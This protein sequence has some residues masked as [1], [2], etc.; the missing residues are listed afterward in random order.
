MIGWTDLFQLLLI[1]F[2][3]FIFLLSLLSILHCSWIL[4]YCFV[5]LGQSCFDILLSSTLVSLRVYNMGLDTWIG[6]CHRNKSWCR[7]QENVVGSL[8]ELKVHMKMM[9]Y[10]ANVLVC[11][12]GIGSCIRQNHPNNKILWLKLYYGLPLQLRLSF[13]ICSKDCR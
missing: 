9:N 11:Q 3:D 8:W 6:H 5:I 13:G 4:I 1:T 2:E 12:L 10:W 7:A